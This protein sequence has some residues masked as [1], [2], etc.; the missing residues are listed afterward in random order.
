MVKP[1]LVA[2]VDPTSGSIHL[3]RLAGPPRAARAEQ[4]AQSERGGASCT[5]YDRRTEAPWVMHKA[6]KQARV[7]A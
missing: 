6:D 3:G 7:S 4:I 5:A 2:K 1:D